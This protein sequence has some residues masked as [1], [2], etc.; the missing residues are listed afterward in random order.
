VSVFLVATIGVAPLVP[1]EHVHAE[2]DH[3][4]KQRV[5]VHRHAD[6]HGTSHHDERH[7]GVPHDGVLDEHG[8]PVLTLTTLFAPPTAPLSVGIVATTVVAVVP[9][10][11]VTG[12][13]LH[14]GAEPLIHGPPRAPASLRAPPLLPA[15]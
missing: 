13:R 5:I 8:S 14:T 2:E 1:P 11:P 3:D 9:Q 4:H 12:R 6:P 15:L 7:D 10:V